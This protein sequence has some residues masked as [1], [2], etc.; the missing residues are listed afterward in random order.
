MVKIPMKY[1]NT[2]DAGQ[3]QGIKILVYGPA[4]SGK[5][6]LCSTV[7]NAVIISAEAGLMSL[8]S[9]NIPVIEVSSA[10]DVTDALDFL[11]SNQEGLNFD[12]ICIDSLSEIGEVILADEKTK[13]SDPRQA[14]LKTQEQIGAIV[15]QFRD[16]PR[17]IYMTA[18]QERIK[19]EASGITLYGPSMPGQKLGQMI[20]YW[21]DEVFAL[22]V[23]ENEKKE[24]QRWLQTGPDIQ[25]GAKDRSGSLAMWESPN[26]GEITAKIK[27]ST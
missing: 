7:E 3:I 8:R 4:G 10:Q 5:T 19:D 20:P 15:R 23:I 26:L 21:F 17:N 14:Y 18:K 11:T 22:R 12:W 1:T 27:K 25:Y 16:M 2:K 9:F 13:V 24:L 6:V